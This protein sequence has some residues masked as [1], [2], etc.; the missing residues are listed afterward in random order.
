MTYELG[1]VFG[2]LVNDVIHARTGAMLV[3]IDDFT[4]EERHFFGLEIQVVDQIVV[5]TLT[6][7]G[8]CRSPV[9]DS[10]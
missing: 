2:Q 6:L 8:H 7:S 9:F 4:C 10:P 3:R 1:I 5:N